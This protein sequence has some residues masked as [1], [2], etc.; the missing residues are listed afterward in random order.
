MAAPAGL[1]LDSSKHGT[2]GALEHNLWVS[3]GVKQ[4]IPVYYARKEVLLRVFLL[5]E[6]SQINDAPGDHVNSL[7]LILRN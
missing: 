4:L 6:V 2:V 5:F 3:H 1:N 7:D